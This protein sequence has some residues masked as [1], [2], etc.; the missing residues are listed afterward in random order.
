MP[1]KISRILIIA[2]GASA[3]QKELGQRIDA[4]LCIGRINNFATEGY[5][6]QLGSRTDIWFNGANQGLRKRSDLQGQRVVVLVPYSEQMRKGETIHSRVQSRLGLDPE[7]YEFTS[8]EEMRQYELESGIERPTTGFNAVLWA[9]RR[10][11]EVIIHGFDFFIDSKSHYHDVFWKKWLIDKGIIKKGGKHNM[12]AE[13]DY[14]KKLL[15][16]DRL[17]R[18]EDIA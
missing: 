5:Q 13:K 3:I 15:S 10:F 1:D 16:E 14:I 4:F 11:D 9:L 18:L 7:K 12:Q 6:T 2:N 17:K 8:A